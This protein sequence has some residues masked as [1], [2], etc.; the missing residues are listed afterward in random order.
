M[1]VRRQNTVRDV[2]DVV[3]SARKRHRD[4]NQSIA[5]AGCTYQEEVNPCIP[6]QVPHSAIAQ[7]IHL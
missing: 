6:S 7:E 4:I 1:T 2:T 3:N 5:V